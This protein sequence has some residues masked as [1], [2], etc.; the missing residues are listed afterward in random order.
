VQ[1][2]NRRIGFTLLELL[3]AMTI[4][5][6]AVL[7]ARVLIEQLADAAQGIVGQG[8]E[9]DE[10]ANSERVLRELVRRLEVGTDDSTRFAGQE[11]IARFTSWCDVPRGWLERC[12]VTL[13]LD[14]RGREPVLAA[15]LSTGEMIVLRRGFASGELRYLSDAARGGSWY[16]SWGVSITAPLAIGLVLDADTLIL[17]IGERG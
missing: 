12:R 11:R 5:T 15:A 7:A 8:S 9:S 6:M 4:A 3:V 17:R 10:D 16:R 14:T 1:H 2:G 13:A